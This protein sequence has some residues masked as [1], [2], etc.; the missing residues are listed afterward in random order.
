MEKGLQK[1][2]DIYDKKIQSLN[3]ISLADTERMRE[4]YEIS[5]LKLEQEI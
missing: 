5:K 1:S 3:A 4:T 2:Q